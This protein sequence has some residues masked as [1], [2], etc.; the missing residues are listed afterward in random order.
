[1]SCQ[2]KYPLTRTLDGM[3]SQTDLNLAQA[4]SSGELR[5]EHR[6]QM[7]LVAEAA[8][9]NPR[10][11]LFDG[12]LERVP[13]NQLQHRMEYAI[14]VRHGIDLLMSGDVAKRRNLSRINA[15]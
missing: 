13:R 11:M 1:M 7:A 5:V 14:V 9:A 15:V 8:R 12:C 4:R 10:R 3:A 2:E 6:S